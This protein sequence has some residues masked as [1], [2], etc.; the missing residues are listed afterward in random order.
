MKK[1][2]LLG[3]L[4]IT[5]LLSGCTPGQPQSSSSTPVSSE[6]SSSSEEKLPTFKDEEFGE[7]LGNYFAKGVT[8]T[9]KADAF[10]L[11]N[12]L[13]LKPTAIEE[14]P[15]GKSVSF[16][17][18]FNDGDFR[19]SLRGESQDFL[20]LLLQKKE[21]GAYVDLFSFMPE[22]KGISGYYGYFE[23]IYSNSRGLFLGTDFNL[24]EGYYNAL[25][26][27]NS[28]AI[29]RNEKI[30]TFVQRKDG[31]YSTGLKLTDA[32]GEKIGQFSV[33]KDETKGSITLVDV[34]GN[35]LYSIA[36][37]LN[38]A[39][40]SEAIPTETYTV[41]GEKKVFTLNGGNE[42]P[43]EMKLD[44][45][46]S[47]VSATIEGIETH[48]QTYSY[49]L[50]KTTLG[51][52]P[53]SV[54]YVFDDTAGLEGEFSS[55]NMTYSFDGTDL[56]INKTK[57]PFT[58]IVYDHMK[59]IKATFAE[60]TYIFVPFQKDIAVKAIVGETERYFFDV[61]S[62]SYDFISTMTTVNDGVHKALSIGNDFQLTYGD[63]HA[64]GQLVYDPKQGDPFFTF[65]LEGTAYVLKV[66]DKKLHAFTLTK[67]SDSTFEEQFFWNETLAKI[68]NDYTSNHLVD[69]SLKNGELTYFGTKL[70]YTLFSQSGNVGFIFNDGKTPRVLQFSTNGAL[71]QFEITQTG[72]TLQLTP[73]K[74][75][76]TTSI[77]ESMVGTFYMNGLFGD[78]KFRL[79]KEGKFYADVINETN[80]GLKYDVEHEFIL[81]VVGDKPTLLFK[82]GTALIY[83][84]YH[85]GKVVVFGMSYVVDYLYKFIGVYGN[86]IFGKS[87][88]IKDD[89]TVFV[90]GEKGTV[91]SYSKIEDVT[92]IELKVGFND[93]V[94]DLKEAT[95]GSKTALLGQGGHETSLAK[96]SISV[97]DYIG[98]YE[99]TV[100]GVK[101]NLDVVVVEDPINHLKTIQVKINGFVVAHSFTFHT[102]QLSLYATSM[103]VKYHI[104]EVDGKKSLVVETSILPPPPPP[105]P[106]PSRS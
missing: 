40:F 7:L 82:Y 41:D 98:S 20:T 89:T 86:D 105:P 80:D 65:T 16:G 43:Y 47:F 21:K 68:E 59:S 26:G 15:F 92:H 32:D 84:Y 57:T 51:T 64:Q 96:Q 100:D 94:I 69:V 79:T 49:G 63:K 74:Y 95:D 42:I 2:L 61:A 24:E 31:K 45:N 1:P 22:M 28:K 78:E 83:V 103:G 99:T 73:S 6:T 8:L 35:H 104:V 44:E 18:K 52:T 12:G 25:E 48:F 77:F 37:L 97:N 56:L 30:E 106:A 54:D 70:N 36:G 3:G 62:F 60:S 4:A 27:F 102:N 13:V 93:V 90:N 101:Y 39:Y 72:D 85:P 53:T 55:G 11:S 46:G 71:T 76:V 75:F 87:L 33:K 19:I 34:D 88:E 5:M 67:V 50:R 29:L 10:T 38:F 9:A 17:A 81:T 23:E 58:Y 14:G 91:S 66:T